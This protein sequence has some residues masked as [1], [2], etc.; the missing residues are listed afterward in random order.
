MAWIGIGIGIPTMG[1]GGVISSLVSNLCS[2]A[3]TC[4]NKSCTK[5][6]LRSFENCA[7]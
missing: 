3:T 7:S 4:E 2:R 5:A 1:S 6:T